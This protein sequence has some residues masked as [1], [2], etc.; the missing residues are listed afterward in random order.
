MHTGKKKKSKGRGRDGDEESDS[1]EDITAK[2]KR[3]RLERAARLLG[4]VQ[5]D[6]VGGNTTGIAGNDS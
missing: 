2:R 1:E 3:E 4:K 5:N 6:A